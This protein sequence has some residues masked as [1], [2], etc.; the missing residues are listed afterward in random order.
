[1]AYVV[2]NEFQFLVDTKIYRLTKGTRLEREEYGYFILEV[3]KG[4]VR[5]AKISIP[6]AVAT[7]NPEF[8]REVDL[9]SD[10]TDILKAGKALTLQKQAKGVAEFVEKHV[11]KNYTNNNELAKYTLVEL[12]T[13]VQ[14]LYACKYQYDVTDDKKHLEPIYTLGWKV[15]DLGLLLPPT[16]Q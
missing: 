13:L 11:L 2:I 9:A 8:F 16:K 3:E 7:D 10:I 6:K 15:D 14:M 4:T 5:E 12:D 1:M